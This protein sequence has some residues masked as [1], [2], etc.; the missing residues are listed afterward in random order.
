MKAGLG[1]A[2]IA[3]PDGLTVAALV[4][5]NAVGDII[6]PGHRAGRRRRA[7]ADGKGLAD[8][9]QLLRSGQLRPRPAGGENTTIGV[10][11]TNA[12]LTK[13]QASKMAQMAHDGFARAISPVHTMGDGDTIFAL[14]TGTHATGDGDFTTIGALAAEVMAD[15]I[16]RA[17][18]QSAGLPEIPSARQLGTIP[19]Q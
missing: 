7:H 10:V 1:S 3:L 18:T 4:A 17:A 11:A 16:V 14:A 5:V 12:R 6:D 9:R 2:A 15:A 8:A 19:K 13:A